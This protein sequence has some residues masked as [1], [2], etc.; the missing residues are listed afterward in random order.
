MISPTLFN[1]EV[2]YS[3]LVSV[4][5]EFTFQDTVTLTSPN[6]DLAELLEKVTDNLE[7]YEALE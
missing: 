2:I 7:K 1:E 4:R 3:P 6:S 5:S